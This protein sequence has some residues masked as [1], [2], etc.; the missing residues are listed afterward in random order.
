MASVGPAS[1]HTVELQSLRGIAAMIVMIHH[2]L[3][4]LQPDGWAWWL[5]EVPLNAEAA[6]II[7]FVLSGYVL[8]ASLMRR[9]LNLANLRIFYGR[10]IFR[11]FPALWVG[12]LLGVV[13]LAWVQPL[14][15][16]HLSDWVNGHYNPEGLGAIRIVGSIAGLDNYLLPPAWSI[17]VELC[18]SAL[19]PPLVWLFLGRPAF[20]WPVIVVLAALCAIA[21]PALRQVPFYLVHFAFG[22][23]LACF[24][25]GR[26]FKPD[27][28]MIVPAVAVLIFAHLAPITQ[29]WW[30]IVVLIEGMASA[31][32]IAGLIARPMSWLQHRGL[33]AIGDWSYSIYILHVPVAF[34]V[35]RMID[36]AGLVGEDR[37]LVSVG[38]ALVTAAIVVPLAGVIYRFIELP[39]ISLGNVVL[40]H[41]HAAIPGHDTSPG[42]AS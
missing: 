21:G 38:V 18:A 1:S 37:N 31:V 16:P 10:R 17:T 12:L 34:A 11:I 30:W 23:A 42:S 8:S 2:C 9:G 33:V 20:G 5:S 29:A 7:F 13:Y 40:K 28:R 25:S 27:V 39:G 19:L 22:A 4:T 35:A 32:L 14:A 36:H 26:N 15:A 6:V 3:R 24:P 41:R